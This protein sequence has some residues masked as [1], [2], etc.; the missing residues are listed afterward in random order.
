[1]TELMNKE[2]FAQVVKD[3]DEWMWT[4]K[5]QLDEWLGKVVDEVVKRTIQRDSR[6]K[7][8]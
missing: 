4:F 7:P 2:Y 3:L 1:V 8:G 6:A 5:P